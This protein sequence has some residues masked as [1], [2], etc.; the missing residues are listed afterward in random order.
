MGSRR[1]SP[2]AFSLT[3]STGAAPMK[4]DPRPDRHAELVRR[5]KQ[6]ERFVLDEVEFAGRTTV[7]VQED[8]IG[9]LARAMEAV[10]KARV[11]IEVFVDA[12]G[13]KQSDASASMAQAMA[14]VRRLVALGVARDRIAQVA[15]G[16]KDPVTPSFTAKGRA[17]NR[18]VE[19]VSSKGR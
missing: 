2:N 8:G 3:F 4:A 1:P 15:K 13:N 5:L 16:G 17:A 7:L 18:R 14:V 6:G 10:P 11:R 12:T 19:V 9:D